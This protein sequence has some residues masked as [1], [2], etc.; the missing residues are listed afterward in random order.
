MNAKGLRLHVIHA[1]LAALTLLIAHPAI[2]GG[3]SGAIFTTD[4]TASFVNG[5]VYDF[6]E[7]VYLNGG[8][9]PN[10]PCTAAGLPDGMYYFQVT[11]P[12]GSV[13]LS[14]DGPSNGEMTVT[15]GVITAYAGSHY[16]NTGK[17]A[18]TT[19]RLA[20][21]NATP[22][23][24]G[25]YKVWMTPALDYAACMCFAPSRSKTDNFKVV[26]PQTD[27]PVTD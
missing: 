16:T 26:A 1:A 17:C 4:M 23:P 5:N 9:R 14:A 20:P 25:V 21:F 13:L 15:G 24:D 8:P 2:A 27:V 12:S 19:V 10:A 6:Q 7:D 18:S 3:L 11:D 22:N